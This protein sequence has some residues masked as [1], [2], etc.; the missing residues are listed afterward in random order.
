MISSHFS[1]LRRLHAGSLM[2]VRPALKDLIIHQCC[3]DVL[4]L[5]RTVLA[6]L[7]LLRVACS[8]NVVELGRDMMAWGQD[9]EPPVLPRGINSF[10]PVFKPSAIQCLGFLLSQ[11]EILLRAFLHF[12]A[13]FLPSPHVNSKG[14]LL[15]LGPRA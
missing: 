6:I 1:Y 4:S 2:S 11:F 3:Q 14:R 10:L 7:L 5:S 13:F 9:C 12:I 8:S 15:H